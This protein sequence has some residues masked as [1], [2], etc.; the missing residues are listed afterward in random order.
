MAILGEV[1]SIIGEI[2]QELPDIKAITLAS[3]DGVSIYADIGFALSETMDEE[4]ISAL[5][6]LIY[7]T[8]RKLNTAFKN[9][10]LEGLTVSGSDGLT[11]VYDVGSDAILIL[12]LPKETNLGLVKIIAKQAAEKLRKLLG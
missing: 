1:R 12:V 7:S 8:A 10:T 9:G 5:G 11:V 2:R 6:V 4:T 3:K